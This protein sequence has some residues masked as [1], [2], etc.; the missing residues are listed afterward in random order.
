MAILKDVCLISS[1]I[2]ECTSVFVTLL[3]MRFYEWLEIKVFPNFGNFMFMSNENFERI[4]GYYQLVNKPITESEIQADYLL[5][6][7]HGSK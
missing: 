1:N 5:R 4:P 3:N 2:A 6:E 7:W